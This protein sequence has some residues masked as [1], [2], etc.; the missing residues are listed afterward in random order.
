M[1]LTYK[2]T[3]TYTYTWKDKKKYFFC[4]EDETLIDFQGYTTT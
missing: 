4:R 3:Y 1:Q 2:H